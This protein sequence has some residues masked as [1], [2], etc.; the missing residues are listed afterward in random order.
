MELLMTSLPIGSLLVVEQGGSIAPYEHTDEP[1]APASRF[2]IA[3][4]IGR[5]EE[6]AWATW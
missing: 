4:I 5:P 6:A 1:I 2:V 3:T